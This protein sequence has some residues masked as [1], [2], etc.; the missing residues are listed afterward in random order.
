M[1]ELSH[2]SNRDAHSEH[3]IDGAR[4]LSHVCGDLDLFARLVAVFLRT[5]P[6]DIA[7]LA[8]AM[9]SDRS[10]EAC[11]LAHRIAGS[12]S[13]MGARTTERLARLIEL[14][15]VHGQTQDAQIAM[16]ELQTALARDLRALQALTFP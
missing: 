6:S 10:E 1:Q 14:E 8:A 9:R 15:L 4:A 11:M 16:G 12:A 7:S 3:A 5:G 2:Q 13:T